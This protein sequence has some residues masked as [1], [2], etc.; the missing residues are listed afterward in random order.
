MPA[1]SR[2]VM[3]ERQS[4]QAEFENQNTGPGLPTTLALGPVC[5]ARR[6]R[7]QGFLPFRKAING[8]DPLPGG[9][10]TEEHAEAANSRDSIDPA[11]LH[12]STK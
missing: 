5:L 11:R 6:S 2:S 10:T 3:V 9:P 8:G 12:G 4:Y 1:V 7:Y